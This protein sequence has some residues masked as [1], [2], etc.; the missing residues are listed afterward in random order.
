MR[1]TKLR[2]IVALALLSLPHVVVFVAGSIWLYQYHMLVWWFLLSLAVTLAGWQLIRGLRHAA[3]PPTVKPDLNWPPVGLAAW[4]EVEALAVRIEGEDIPLAEPEQLWATLRRVIEAV[5][6]HYRPQ[7]PQPWLDTPFPHVMRIAELVARDLRIATLDYVPGSHI[8]TIRDWQRLWRL[9][10]HANRLYPW[11]RVY[12]FLVSAPAALVREA[13]DLFFRRFTEASIT[14]VKRWAVGFFVR[15]AGF[16]A[17]QLYGGYLALDDRERPGALTTSSRSD[18]AADATRRELLENEPLR[19]LV[20]GQLKAGKSSLINALFD[21]YRAAVDVVPRTQYV[22]PFVL[23]REGLCQAIILDSAGYDRVEPEQLFREM[24]DHLRSCDVVLCACSA[25]SATRSADRTFL[26]ALRNRFQSEPTLHVPVIIVVVTKID[27]LRPLSE[28]NPPYCL[29]PPAGAK[30][31]NI[32]AVVQT[33]ANDLGIAVDDVAPVC[34]ASGQTYNID[35]ALIPLIVER[36]PAADRVRYLR[37]LRQHRDE[38]YWR[39]LWRQSL[40]A[41]RLLISRSSAAATGLFRS[42]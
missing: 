28:W 10:G 38:H 26:D 9:A 21:D 13:R 17:I 40:G 11:Y 29:A 25:T 20:V 8:L 5:A 31:N 2:W 16:Y 37:T 7:S 1:A 3:K 35:E 27:Q 33:V 23:E 14:E 4:A 34:L 18:V 42:S 36:L 41:G 19:V 30:A 39:R 12:T 6:R 24:G 15:R 32:A 22:E